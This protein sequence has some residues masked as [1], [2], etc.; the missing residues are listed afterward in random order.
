MGGT[1]FG[2]DFSK[3][4]VVGEAMVKAQVPNEVAPDVTVPAKPAVGV[5][6]QPK[7]RCGCSRL[8]S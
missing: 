8:C 2:E 6:G 1:S 5:V 7:L 3:I 4:E